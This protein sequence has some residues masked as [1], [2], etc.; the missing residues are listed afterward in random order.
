[1]P[2]VLDHILAPTFAGAVI[3]WLA[4]LEWDPIPLSLQWARYPLAALRIG[5]IACLPWWKSRPEGDA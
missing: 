3:L 4:V 2:S 1:M 5:G